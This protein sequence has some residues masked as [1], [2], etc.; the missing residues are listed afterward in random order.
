METSCVVLG[1]PRRTAPTQRNS[2]TQLLQRA[3]NAL[4]QRAA[5]PSAKGHRSRTA[6]AASLTAAYCRPLELYC[7][8]LQA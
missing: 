8:Y 7:L 3:H 1:A 4:P 2:S 5:C 6:H